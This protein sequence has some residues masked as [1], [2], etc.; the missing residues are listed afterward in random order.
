MTWVMTS[1][2]RGVRIG[3]AGIDRVQFGVG[4]ASAGILLFGARN[5]CQQ[6][7]VVDGLGQEIDRTRPHGANAGRDVALAGQENDRPLRPSRGQRLLQLQP[8]ETRHGDIEHRAAGNRRI[9]VCEKCLRRRERL[10]VVAPR[11]QQPRQ[12]FQHA[13][14]VVDKEDRERRVRHCAATSI[15]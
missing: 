9:V 5:R 11:A 6:V 12:S 7:G 4:V 8:I 14:I 10:D 15:S 1:R 3:K 13:G 2:S